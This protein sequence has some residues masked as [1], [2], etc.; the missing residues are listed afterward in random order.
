MR[1]IHP[2]VPTGFEPPAGLEDPAFRLRPLGPKHNVSDYL[3]WTSSMDHIHA[4]PGWETSTWP[5]QM[6][7]EENQADL[8]RHAAD[9]ATHAGFTDTVLAP[10]SDAVI[11]GVW[12][13][14]ARFVYAPR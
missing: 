11:G 12:W 9:F 5:R 14:F 13:P 6:S 2:F 8:E 10:D 1:V 4:T 7:L 3:A